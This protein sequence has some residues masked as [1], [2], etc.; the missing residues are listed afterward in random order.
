MMDFKRNIK[1]KRKLIS[2]TNQYKSP[3]EGILDDAGSNTFKYFML[4]IQM[5]DHGQICNEKPSYCPDEFFQI[6]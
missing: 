5:P 3:F 1:N 2:C 6:N 4:V